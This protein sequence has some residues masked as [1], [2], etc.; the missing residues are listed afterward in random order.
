MIQKISKFL[1]NEANQMVK[2]AVGVNFLA[3]RI[4]EIA[5]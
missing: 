2:G 4:E 5:N 1:V 3:E